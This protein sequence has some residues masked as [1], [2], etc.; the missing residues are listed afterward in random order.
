MAA[1]HRPWHLLRD[2]PDLEVERVELP[3]GLDGVLVE[4]DDRFLGILLNR[5]LLRPERDATLL[6]EIIHIRRG[7]SGWRPGLPPHLGALVAKEEHRVDRIV[8]ETLAPDDQLELLR[9]WP[10][11]VTFEE[12]AAELEVPVEVLRRRQAW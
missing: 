9:R 6:H 7:G 10:D 3:D 5:R 11:P 12:A 1:E 2:L 8:A 4:A